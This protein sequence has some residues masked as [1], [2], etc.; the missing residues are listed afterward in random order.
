MKISISLECG[1]RMGKENV[2]EVA[3]LVR[4]A[5]FDGIDLSMDRDISVPFCKKE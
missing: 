2:R 1:I 5:G 4:S 3:A